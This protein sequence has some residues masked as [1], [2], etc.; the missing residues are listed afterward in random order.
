LEDKEK[1]RD[2]EIEDA[3]EYTENIINTVHDP[4]IILFEDLRVALA[5]RAFYQAFRVTANETEGEFIYTLGN[6]QWDI[7]KLRHLLEDILPQNT[8]FDNFEIEHDFPNIGKRTML[9]NACRIYLKANRTKLIILT[10]K[11]ISEH[12]KL[13]ELRGKIAELESQLKKNRKL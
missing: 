7:P 3:L 2:L 9:L 10:I 4:L 1:M 11:D 13:D 6:H 5:S 8:S 12:K